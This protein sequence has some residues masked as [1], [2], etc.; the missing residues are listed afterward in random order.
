M[1]MWVLLVLAVFSVPAA[2]GH[3]PSVSHLKFERSGK[4]IEGRLDIALRDLEL[5]IGL[6]QNS[7]L[8]ITWGELRNSHKAIAEYAFS[9]LSIRNERGACSLFAKQHLVETRKR[10]GF[11]VILF[12]LRC[13][14]PQ[15]G[16]LI[17]SY[18]LLFDLDRGHRGL[19]YLD[20]SA[21]VDSFDAE[22]RKK[23]VSVVLRKA[24]KER[25]SR[26]I[27]SVGSRRKSARS[28]ATIV[29]EINRPSSELIS[30]VENPRTANPAARMRKL[31]QSAPPTVDIA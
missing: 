16:D 17:I 15:H 12:E 19:L 3:S 29:I 22:N 30:K 2:S 26:R 23:R 25:R 14:A 13:P 11:A 20:G 18:N 1:S 4:S 28:A 6:D 9:R 10:R 24:P 27:K 21:Q 31:I 5:A 7:D 8:G